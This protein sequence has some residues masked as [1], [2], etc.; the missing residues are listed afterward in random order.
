MEL[1]SIILILIIVIIIIY[2]YNFNTNSNYS[3]RNAN[4]DELSDSENEKNLRLVNEI[5]LDEY[6]NLLDAENEYEGEIENTSLGDQINIS[7]VRKEY[8]GDY[9]DA[10]QNTNE[11]FTSNI[12]SDLCD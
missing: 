9:G 6:G 2:Y 7:D 10:S 12:K 3:S 5:L 4:K 11:D 8:N 1:L